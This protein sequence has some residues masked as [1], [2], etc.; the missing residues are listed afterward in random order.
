MGIIASE[1]RRG[2]T[3]LFDGEPV[4]VLDFHHHTPGNLRAMVQTK[5]RKLR[6]GTQF[7]HRFRSTDTVDTANLETH[8]L[9][10]M[11]AGGDSYHFMNT[12]NFDQ[13]E[14]NE[15]DLGEAA[16]W[17]TGG[18]KLIA[19]YFN[20]RPIGIQL[21]NALVYEVTETAPVMKT[22]TKNASTKPAKLENGVSVNVPE[23]VQ[24]GE[25]V[26][27]NPNT[28]EYLDRVK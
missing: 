17:M 11:Y 16:K 14:M 9:E 15:E 24:T 4:R 7:E 18:M 22:A 10:F 28:G 21:P 20:G 8:E 6:T 27:V 25:K 26:R 1:I 19:E 13:L 23:F 2:M 3:L 5:L 12:E